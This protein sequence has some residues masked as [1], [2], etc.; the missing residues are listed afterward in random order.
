VLIFIS[1]FAH[2]QSS[3][4]VLVL[5]LEAMFDVEIVEAWSHQAPAN[6]I[7]TGLVNITT[8]SPPHPSPGNREGESSGVRMQTATLLQ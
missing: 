1:I 8:S 5:E 2:Y 4:R 6:T 7:H 3:L